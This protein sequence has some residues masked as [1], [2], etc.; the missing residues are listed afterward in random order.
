MKIWGFQPLLYGKDYEEVA[1]KSVEPAVDKFLILYTPIPSYGG[2]RNFVCSDSR[3]ELYAIAQRALGDKLLWIEPDHSYEHEGIHRD[4]GTN[5]ARDAGVD[6]LVCCDSD[7]LWDL[8]SLEKAIPQ[9]MVTGARQ[10]RVNFL[11]FWKS[12]SWVNVD[13]C[14]AVRLIVPH[15][16]EGT[17]AYLQLDKPIYHMGYAKTNANMRQKWAK[18]HGH[19]SDLRPGWLDFYESWKPGMMDCHPTNSKNFWC[20]EPFDRTTL[21]ELLKQHPYYDLDIIE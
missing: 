11:H 17:E 12:F 21:P 16:P 7:E 1:L 18:I 6:L 13:P 14:M 4:R 3:E 2:D 20:P 5:I 10:N 9:A 8:P 19:Q 15:A